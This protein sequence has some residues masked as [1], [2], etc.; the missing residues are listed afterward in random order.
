MA[1]ILLENIVNERY[2][3]IKFVSKSQTP[4]SGDA[5]LYLPDDKI[6]MLESKNY[7][8]TVNKDEVIK[9][10]SDMITHNITWGIL[11]SFNSMIQGM[12]ELDFHT[13]LH[14]HEWY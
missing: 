3:D 8:S 14:N 7:T 4:H 2:G 6:I 12:K 5:W 10:Q 9:L 13:F 11:V 1:E